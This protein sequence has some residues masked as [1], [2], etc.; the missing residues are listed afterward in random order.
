MNRP[1][2]CAT[3]NLPGREDAGHRVSNRSD[4]VIKPARACTSAPATRSEMDGN[5]RSGSSRPPAAAVEAAGGDQRLDQIL[6]D[7]PRPW[8]NGRRGDIS[9][10]R[11]WR[12]RR[13]RSAGAAPKAD[14]RFGD[15]AP[16]RRTTVSKAPNAHLLT[17]AK[18]VSVTRRD[19]SLSRPAHHERCRF[20]PFCSRPGSSVPCFLGMAGRQ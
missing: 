11:S 7:L 5:S 16:C 3:V 9:I 19:L 2:R 4:Q 8:R 13:G 6:N 12:G 14:R 10:C 18:A 1:P 20:Q 15:M 17:I